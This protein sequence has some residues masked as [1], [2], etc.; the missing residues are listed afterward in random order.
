MEGDGEGGATLNDLRVGIVFARRE[1]KFLCLFALYKRVLFLLN[2][3]NL[4]WFNQFYILK[5]KL[6]WIEYFLSS[7]IGS[8][9]F[10][11]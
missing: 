5:S 1:Y 9:D 11:I 3:F 8:F 4:V 6:N 7:L 2:W 10:F